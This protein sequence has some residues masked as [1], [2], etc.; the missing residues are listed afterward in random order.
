MQ[1]VLKAY[2]LLTKPGIIYG[3]AFTAI[4]GFVLASKGYIH[5]GL[6]LATLLG[7]SFIIASAC[8]V[9]NYIDRNIDN[10]MDRTKNRALVTG[11]VP[12]RI[13]IIYALALGSIGFGILAH[14]TNLLTVFL[15]CIAFFF[16]VVLY[17][18]GKRK[19]T[20]GTLIGSVSGALPPVAGYCAVSNSFD[21]G[22]LLLFLLLTVWQMPHFYAIAIYRI[23]DYTSAGIPVLPIKK[24]ISI[25]KISMLVYIL[26]FLV[27]SALFTILHVSGYLYFLAMLIVGLYWLLFGIIGLQT[28]DTNKWARKMFFISLIVILTFSLMLPID[29]ILTHGILVTW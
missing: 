4:A 7:I 16:Y 9:N 21:T 1:Q 25:T 18:L 27:T 19:S 13:A 28:K 14:Y 23:K 17:S 11:Q 22:A 8:V 3:N 15:G 20:H 10:K 29:S 24:G 2:Y 26:A 5:I 12:I 6:L